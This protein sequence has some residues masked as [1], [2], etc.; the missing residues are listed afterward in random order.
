MFF[1]RDPIK[2]PSLNRS[3]KRNPRTHRPDANMV[4]RPSEMLLVSHGAHA[5]S[6]IVLGVCRNASWWVTW[7]YAD[8]NSFHNSSPEGFHQIIQLFSDRGTP[9]S[10][11]HMNA[12]SGHT[13]KLTTAVSSYCCFILATAFLAAAN[14]GGIRMEALDTSSSTLRQIRGC[15]TSLERRLK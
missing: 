7:Y 15:V 5:D 10:L 13:Y 11:R 14:F 9:A 12:Y 6:S 8:L 3:H 1:I 2:F 4:S